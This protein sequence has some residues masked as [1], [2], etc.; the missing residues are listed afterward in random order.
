MLLKILRCNL[1]GGFK[2]QIIV[3]SLIGRYYSKSLLT[4]NMIALYITMETKNHGCSYFKF[5]VKVPFIKLQ[6]FCPLYDEISF[7]M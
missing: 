7:S 5:V 3:Y 4:V 1:Y 2:V 6:T